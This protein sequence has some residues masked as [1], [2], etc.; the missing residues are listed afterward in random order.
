MAAKQPAPKGTVRHFH[1]FI[2]VDKREA[3]ELIQGFEI[4][5][6]RAVL[7]VRPD[8]FEALTMLGHALTKS[9]Q[10]KQAL[11]VDHKLAKI[12]ADDPIVHYNLACSLSNLE[13]VDES[14]DALGRALELGYKDFAYMLGDPDL[15]NVRR[16]PRFKQLLDR[17]WGKRQP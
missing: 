8:W 4:S 16:D 5:L 14:L 13:R 2:E 17:R 12:R 3:D 10:H 6:S 11:A 9:G 15:Q 1:K 7:K